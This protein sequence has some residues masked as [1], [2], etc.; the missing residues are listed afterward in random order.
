MTLP[1][2]QF[3]LSRHWSD[4]E[5]GIELRIWLIQDGQSKCWKLTKQ[6]SVCF[7][8]SNHLSQWQSVWARFGISTDVSN[9]NFTALMGDSVVPVYTSSVKNQRRWVRAGRDIGLKVWEDDVNPV[10]RFLMERFLFGSVVFEQNAAKPANTEPE[11]KV[12]SLDIETS[13]YKPGET[14]D[15][16]SVALAGKGYKR[17]FVIEP[18]ISRHVQ[19]YSD[20][21]WCP[22]VQTCLRHVIDAIEHFDPDC[23][24]GWNVIDFDL[25]ILQQHCDRHDISFSIGRDNQLVHWRRQADK[26]DRFYIEVEG[27]Q[28]VD[29]PGA[30][31]SAAWFF[32][33]FS[34]ETVSQTILRRGKKIE[35][36]D[37]KVGEIERMYRED[38]DA[39]AKYNLEDA[40]LVLE[41][42]EVAGLWHFLIQRSHLTGLPMERAGGSSAAFNTVYM[43]RLHRAGYIASSI[44][45]QTLT[46]SSPGGFVMDSIP[47]IYSDVLVL[48]FKSLYPSIIRTFLIDPLGLQEGL[49]APESETVPGFL[50][51]KFHRTHHILPSLIDMLWQARDQAK[52]EQNAPL[53]QA[54]K[55]IMNSFY[56]VLGSHLCRFFDPRLA[57]SITMRGHEILQQ[58]G[59]FI[60]RAGYQVIYG[61]TDSVFV[62]AKDVSEPKELGTTL[63]KALN[64]WWTDEI[65]T[66]FGIQSHLEIEFE[67]HYSQFVMPTIRGTEKGSKKR[68]AGWIE[69]EQGGK[70]VFKG[71][72]AVRSDWTPLAKQFQIGLYERVFNK[73]DFTSYIQET[74]ARLKDGSLDDQLIYRRR[75]RRGVEQY[76]KQLPPQVQAALLKRELNPD[77]R[78]RT[79]EYVK[80]VSGWQ[81]VPFVT[82]ALDYDH[83]LQKQLAPIA[84]A[85]LH[86][87]GT[88]FNRITREQMSLF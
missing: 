62:H 22:D 60:E 9:K 55:I 20:I 51:A 40:Q 52:Q 38:I 17:V 25:Q 84:D 29:G 7:V 82:A 74:V 64:Q 4:T 5:Q 19:A 86:F 75:L 21:V 46:L 13:W 34:L 44:G 18:D 77:W 11:L 53:S 68:Y 3:I 8:S 80:T 67:T 50:D 78:G 28:V 36:N 41:L 2:P 24:I 42:F 66:H 72:E 59:K 63:A 16:Y 58:T 76:Q 47:G 61:D 56:G 6:K 73:V 12:L 48:D 26:T 81:P 71:L 35:H 39:F 79:I 14:P 54:I 31:R 87:L 83:Y 70:L 88:D 45:E 43:P 30:F 85:I 10:E 33:D 49:K 27:R 65:Q 32:D 1:T 15:L 23:L 69:T 37:D 57:S